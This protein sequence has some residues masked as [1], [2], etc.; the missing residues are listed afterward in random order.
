MEADDKDAETW[1]QRYSNAC[2]SLGL[3]KD[4]DLARV[5]SLGEGLALIEAGDSFDLIVVSPGLPGLGPYST[6]ALDAIRRAAPDATVQIYA[7][8]QNW[9]LTT[10]IEYDPLASLAL[11]RINV[12]A[13]DT[14]L[15]AL[16]QEAYRRGKT[17]IRELDRQVLPLAEKVANFE[18][19]LD[20]QREALS[21]TDWSLRAEVRQAVDKTAQAQLT[22]VTM[23]N[24][25]NQLEDR[26][27][28]L[29]GVRKDIEAI[30][31]SLGLLVRI[32]SFCMRRWKGL[33]ALLA[34]S[35]AAPFI[36]QAL[37]ELLNGAS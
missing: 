31:R 3:P 19:E 8:A 22:L 30:R 29:R 18:I 15:E 13:R 36:L 26:M 12:G 20:R 7:E 2:D 9:A 11:K 16:I 1:R 14:E 32:S 27:K 10:Q 35:S 28:A 23:E 34:S 17:A 5:R 4:L 24:Q 33:L 37:Q 6:E 21:R 25:L